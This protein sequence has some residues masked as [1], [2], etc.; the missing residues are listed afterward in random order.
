MW[1]AVRTAAS[2]SSVSTAQSTLPPQSPALSPFQRANLLLRERQWEAALRAYLETWVEAPDL[3]GLVRANLG[4]LLREAPHGSLP[5]EASA[6]ARCLLDSSI[7]VASMTQPVGERRHASSTAH[8]SEL[9]HLLREGLGIDQVYV[10]NLAR[11]PDR[12]IRILREM[13]A[14]GVPVARIDGVDAR[15]STQARAD[16]A[17]FRARPASERR[18]SS[19]HVSE[20]RMTRYKT[21]VT[22]GAFGYNLSQ[23]RVIRDAQRAGHRRIL[24]LDDDV[25]FA[26]DARERLAQLAPALPTDLKVLL[27]GASEY[28]DR[29]SEAFRSLRLTGRDDL[30]RPVPS[31]TCGSFAVVYDRSAYDEVLQA[32]GEA[33]G[34]YDNVVLGALYH[35]HPKQCIAVDPA[36]CIPDVGDSDIRPNA[37]AQQAHSRRMRWEFTRYEAFTAPMQISVLVSSLDSLRLVESMRHEL[38][39]EMFLNIFY[40]SADGLRSVIV[41]HHFAPRD[42][43]CLPLEAQDGADLREEAEGLGVPP[44]DVVM[45][46]PAHLP[47]TE[48]AAVRAMARALEGLHRQG[49]REGVVDGIAYRIDAGRRP[50]RGRHSV[51]IPSFRTVEQVWPTVQSALLQDAADVEVIVVSDNPEHADFKAALTAR[52][53]AWANEM[54]RPALTQRL[55]VLAHQR[56]RNASAARNTGLWHS[57]GEF[58]SFLDDDDIFAPARLSAVEPVIAAAPSDVH[59]CYCGYSGSWNGEPDPARFPEGDLGDRVLSLRYGEHYMCTNTVSFK[60]SGLVRLGGFNEA[61]GRHQDLELMA[62]YFEHFK[63]AALQRFLVQNRPTP[64]SQ[65]FVADLAKL[66]ALKQ[67]FLADFRTSI[68][69]RGPEFTQQVVEAHL[70][71]ITKKYKKPPEELLV[72]VRAFL[73]GALRA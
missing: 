57:T 7:D 27:L 69:A 15:H 26:S 45:A 35:R 6:D 46:W 24:V 8:A 23:A 56:N 41:G 64:V 28:S 36:I 62:R 31:V 11:R 34:T 4:Q 72:S 58:V 33:D 12:Y 49:L 13:N 37:R 47:V 65:T 38:P 1:R 25:F 55:Q 71:D 9:H 10:V 18:P 43:E 52:A 5:A 50:V 22:V 42:Q 67:Q 48:D 32:I 63:I 66:C 70:K 29:H 54:Q 16:H 51:I 60:R 61:Y 39:S 19:Q 21:E 3:R 2:R 20:E 59:A 53:A 40:R 17:A 44:S 14:W 30:Y 73:N 68:L